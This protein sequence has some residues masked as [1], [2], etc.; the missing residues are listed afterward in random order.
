MRA[1]TKS[2]LTQLLNET[3]ESQNY[4]IC[5][6]ETHE[7][8]S[9]VEIPKNYH[10]IAKR[11]D[12][13]D[14]K[15]GG[16]MILK[17]FID[18]MSEMEEI[19]VKNPDILGIKIH[20]KG[21]KFVLILI[22]MDVKDQKRN[23]K[24]RKDIGDVIQ[25]FENN[26]MIILGDFN[27]HLGFIGD[28]RLDLN[29]KFVLNLMEKENMILLNNDE[30]CDGK[31]TREENNSKSAIDFVLVNKNMYKNFEKMTIDEERKHYDLS[32]HCVIETIFKLENYKENIHVK[33]EIIEY[34]SV[35]EER[36]EQ[37]LN[38][39]EMEF[40]RED[41]NME[42]MEQKISDAV[43]NILKKKFAPK[44]NQEAK[45]DPIWFNQSIKREIKL[46]QHYNRA[47]RNAKSTQERERYMIMY[48]SQKR[49]VQ[50]MI[51]EAIGEYEIKMTEE[52]KSKKSSKE[53]WNNIN[54]LRGRNCIKKEHKLYSE[55]EDML[56]DEETKVKIQDFWTKIYHKHENNIQSEWSQQR[57]IKYIEDIQ[58]S[59]TVRVEFD[60]MVP[61][62]MRTAYEFVDRIYKRMGKPTNQH[63]K[64]CKEDI[65]YMNITEDL[66]EHYDG[67]ARNYLKENVITK[68]ENVNINEEDVRRH[69]RKIKSGKRAGPD[70]V[71]P[72]IYKWMMDSQLCIRE[73]TSCLNEVI[74]TGIFPSKWRQ[75]DTILI[76]KKD[77]PKTN[78]L[79]PIALTN[80]S[81]KLFMAVLKEKITTHLQIN[82]QFSVYQAG[83]TQ[84]RR[85]ED[86]ILALRY[87][88]A[89]SKKNKKPL[90]LAAIDFA[91]AF[92][93][94]KREHIIIAMK[95]YKCDPK[96][97]DVMAALYVEDE[98]NISFN[99]KNMGTVSVSSGIRQ[100]CTGSPLLFIMVLNYIIDKIVDT[101]LGFKN[102]HIYMP[103]LFFADDGLVLSQSRG[104][105][106]KLIKIL[107]TSAADVGLQINKEKS[108][109]MIFNEKCK[110]REIEKIKVNSQI[111]YLG[112]TIN[113]TFNCYKEYK[114]DK[115]KQAT[116]MSNMAYS[117]IARSCN[118]ILIGKTYWKGVVMPCLLYGLGVVTWSKT[119]LEIMQRAE[120]S[121]WRCV[122][123]APSYTPVASMRGEIGSSTME[124]RDMK[125]K[126]K[127]V[128]YLMRSGNE[129]MRVIIRDLMSFKTDPYVKK[130]EEYLVTLNV[131]NIEELMRLSDR[132][133]EEK[134]KINDD[135][136]WREDILGKTTL[137][138]YAAYKTKIK[139]EKFYTNDEGSTLVFRART[140]T[141]KLNW[142]K[143]FE[144]GDI[145]CGLCG[146]EE[147]T[148]EHFLKRCYRL[149]GVRREFHVDDR[150]VEEI[151]LLRGEIDPEICK[152][153][154]RKAWRK[155]E[156][157]LKAMA[158]NGGVND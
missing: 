59:N 26:K 110:P 111:K 7:K 27:G 151:L 66:M 25:K 62:E 157:I 3:E 35:K 21:I 22:Y 100:G 40:I 103:V 87:C 63:L 8:Y 155:R 78:E 9:S 126:I 56:S 32:D 117:V 68:M 119:E 18:K 99:G 6:N 102:D 129:M 91:K 121:V 104:E 132:Q 94:I 133:V 45:V 53:L 14:K 51:K 64:T 116:K 76:P 112:V 36:K 130:I 101:K 152:N 2:K 41:M 128:R 49:N 158:I 57:K 147:E 65:E 17:Q 47:K 138:H 30:K 33:N 93:S 20:S 82:E 89:D 70:K 127:Y 60:E 148:L 10:T 54:K 11:R 125:T 143:R 39:I 97:I 1:M 12:L 69:I 5:M 135:M 131:G 137:V 24:I 107:I 81:Y 71:K 123:G 153:Y 73:L 38:H 44:K 150:G 140:N 95:K 96:I 120:N 75:S 139:E 43:Q 90:Y 83:F 136:I 122:L 16:L 88:I 145:M 144:G 80:V 67:V 34:I 77:K 4:L 149:E 50:E 19:E 85:I 15:G 142:R 84:G 113:D 28:Q 156:D 48:K 115:L 79:R 55:S 58:K 105:L 134:I 106:Q 61:E 31:Y 141:L 86:N 52:I 118:K 108:N 42:K 29:G 146:V 109:I 46:R 92:D 37:F 23:D 124:N 74:K 72:E 114:K 98:T 154:I 13:T